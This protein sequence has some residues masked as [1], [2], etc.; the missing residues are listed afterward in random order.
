M[1]GIGFGLLVLTA[2]LLGAAFPAFVQQ[3]QVNPSA[4]IREQPYI[5]RNIQSTRHAYGVDSAEIGD[6]PGTVTPPSADVLDA[7]KGT[8]NNIR[9]LDPAVVAPTFQQLQQVRAYYAFTQTLDIDRYKINGVQRGAVVSVRDINIAGVP[10]NQRNWANDHAVY[11]HGYGFVSAY[12][13][14]AQS[15]GQPDFF[16]SDIPETGALA[17]DQPRIYFGE[18]SPTFSV[19]GAPAGSEPRELDYPDDQTPGGQKLNTY[20]GTGGASVGSF[21]QRLVF[22]TKFQDS[23]ILLSDL[24]NSDSRILWDRE[25]LS[26]V[27]KV[28]PWLTLDQDPYPAVINGRVVWIVDGYTTTEN[29]SYSSRVSLSDATSDSISVRTASSPLAPDDQVN[30]VRNSVKATV[31]AYDGTVHLYAWDENDPILQTWSKVF[32]GLI[33]S[34]SNMPSELVDHIRYPEDLFKLQRIVLSRYHVTDP[35]T[36]YNGTDFWIVPFDPTQSVQVF[37]PPYYLTLQMPGQTAPTF[38][39]TTTFAPQRR[40]TLAAF[41]AVDSAP[42]PGY[43]TIRVLQLPSN[44]TI[45]GPEQVQNN[46]ESDPIVSSQLSLL[47]KGGSEVNLGNLLSLPFNGG[48]LYVE[49]VYIQATQGGYPLLRKVLAGYGGNVAMEDTLAAAL[50]KVFSATPNPSPD[51][52]P[53]PGPSPSPSP[54]PDPSPSPS[55]SPNPSPSPSPTTDPYA[56]LA[57]AISDAQ[58][59]Y[60]AGQT[61]LATSDF[62]AY[63]VAQKALEDALARAAA[64]EKRI[65]GSGAPA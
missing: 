37:Q 20:D 5:D 48:L 56:D 35:T 65:N 47:R 18:N 43:G 32:P 21:F 7:S 23:N 12:D 40:Q 60:E 4:L 44:T 6:Y 24:I 36:F 34:K 25:P 64:A 15:S 42:G 33:E 14:T 27:E 30:Y 63:G 8:L 51:P 26:M 53:D 52:N 31:D 3:F 11:T 46:F 22:A 19:V 62:A 13:N 61:A 41:M 29:Y 49:P 50:T 9:L 45:P 28:A 54:S 39:L 2:I 10:D 16:E 58:T 17:I 57:A 38:S 55:P 59:A 1:A